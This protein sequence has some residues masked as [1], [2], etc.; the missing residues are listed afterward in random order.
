MYRDLIRLVNRKKTCV[1][2]K[3]KVERPGVYASNADLVLNHEIS[4][5][6]TRSD[7]FLHR[8]SLNVCL[9]DPSLMVTSALILVNTTRIP[10]SK[11]HLDPP[12]VWKVSFLFTTKL[13]QSL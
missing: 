11:F 10:P 8:R 7:N 12:P 5:L 13:A 3:G 4:R 9:S 6:P 1:Q 2:R